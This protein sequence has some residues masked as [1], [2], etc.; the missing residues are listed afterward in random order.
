M[1][2]SDVRSLKE[3]EEENRRLKQMYAEL[4]LKSQMQEDII[5][6]L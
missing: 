6:K 3:L 4:S 1:E 2:A 5:K